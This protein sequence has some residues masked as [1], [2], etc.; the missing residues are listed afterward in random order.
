MLARHIEVR[1]A[2]QPPQHRAR[3]ALDL[4]DPL[5]HAMMRAKRAQAK[6]LAT[7]E[8]TLAEMVLKMRLVEAGKR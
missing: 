6:Q 7:R 2:P 1:Y 8:Q 5:F 4:A 3:D